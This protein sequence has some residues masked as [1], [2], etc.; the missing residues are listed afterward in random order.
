MPVPTSPAPPPVGRDREIERLE[1]TLTGRGARFA[2][3]SGEAGIGKTTVLQHLAGAA[4][5]QGRLVLVG[6]AAEY[7]QDTPLGVF[8][9]ALDTHLGTIDP[10]RLHRF[11]PEDKAELAALFPALRGLGDTRMRTPERSGLHRAVRALLKRLAAGYGLALFLEDLHWADPASLELLA[12]LVRRPLDADAL[13][14]VSSRANPLDPALGT[15][16]ADGEPSGVVTRVTLGPL[17]HEASNVIL[18]TLSAPRRDALYAESGGNPFFLEQLARVPDAARTPEPGRIAALGVPTAVAASL[19]G[20][21]APLPS[22]ARAFLEAAAVTGEPFDATVAAQVADLPVEAFPGTLAQLLDTDLIRPASD[23]GRYRFRHP[24]VRRSVYEASKAGWRLEAH[25]RAARLLE[26]EGAR[27]SALAHHVEQSARV[28]DEAAI[29]VLSDAAYE[30][31]P[32]APAAAARWLEAALRLVPGHGPLHAR[33]AELLARA[34]HAMTAIGRFDDGRDALLEAL[35]LN[36]EAGPTR[37][38]LIA[39]IATIERLLGRHGDGK[40]RL[41]AALDEVEDPYSP[42]AVRLRLELTAHAAW[43]SDFAFVKVCAAESL[44]GAQRVDDAATSAAATAAT[45]YAEY[46]VGNFAQA[47][48]AADQA[49]QLVDALDDAAIAPRLGVFIFLGAATWL[50]GQFAVSARQHA[51]G[52]RVSRATGQ[53]ANVIDLTVGLAISLAVIGKTAEA[54]AHAQAAVEEARLAS[55]PRALAWSLYGACTA[56]ETM[57]LA[58]ALPFGEEAVVA[59]RNIEASTITGSCG[60]AFAAALVAAG[61]PERAIAILLELQGGED[62]PWCLAG[63]RTASFEVLIQ[64]ELLRGNLPAAERW[65]TRM[66]E[67]DIEQLPHARATADRAEA[68]LRLAQGDAEVAIAL[69]VA[70]TTGFD[71]VGATVAA[72]RSRI[73]AGRALTAAGDR[74]R[75]A[76][77]LRRAEADTAACGAERIRLDAVRE[78]RRIGR[79]VNRRG[80]DGHTDVAGFSALSPREL[81]V[82]RLAAAGE[83]N[84]SIAST[85]FLSEK[86]V[87]SHLASAFVKLGVARRGDLAD[88]L[89]V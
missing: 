87:E 3:V 56:L 8:V 27:P 10:V 34:A 20:E 69:A 86:T 63:N 57:S 19:A 7:E 42:D 74:E 39:G 83:T 4:E 32:R 52:L 26:A 59:A 82:A 45:A 36:P 11:G 73:V 43:C 75:A 31:V 67:A 62:L 38:D 13:I 77:E 2:V 64:A 61:E 12:S 80:R 46:C 25:A 49:S 14:A 60:F 30:T 44:R 15:A 65:A 79:R 9:D 50:N 88:A 89:A 48:A 84:R 71:A 5:E 1:A 6:R 51:R 55:S 28:G 18:A 23:D 76:T 17:S 54:V 21:V 40:A 70:A 66:R 24:L 33:R 41:L 68:Q 72:A 47:R 78:L 37:T 29:A 22:A 81:E 58:D 85:L 53:S 35:K 16:L